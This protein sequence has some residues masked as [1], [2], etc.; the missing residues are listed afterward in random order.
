MEWTR[1]GIER[2]LGR[3]PDELIGH[4]ARPFMLRWWLIPHNRFFNIYL[5]HLLRSDDDRALHDHP[6]WS[7]SIMLD[8]KYVEVTADGSREYK[9]G[10]VILRRARFAHRL[11]LPD[12]A[13]PLFKFP[14]TTLFLTG[15]RVREWGFHCPNGWRHHQTF[16]AKGGCGERK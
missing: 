2:R 6:W 16:A 8:G 5:H 9:R 15:P 14:C 3:K 12:S 1:E 13:W 10:A 7:L 11:K 4:E